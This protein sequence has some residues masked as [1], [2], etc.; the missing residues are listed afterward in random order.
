MVKLNCKDTR[1]VKALLRLSLIPGLLLMFMLPMTCPS[2]REVFAKGEN[3][4]D[5]GNVL[6]RN[7]RAVGAVEPDGR[8]TN[9]Y[10]K[11]IGSVDGSGKVFNV[12]EKEVGNISSS[13]EVFN[14]TGTLL[15]RVDA[16]GNIYRRSGN[17]VGSVVDIGGNIN[18]I[19]GAARL[20]LLK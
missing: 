14:Q 8:V 15:G 20:L 19:G 7:G 17:K 4:E 10:G 12:R 1:K 2:P 9:R 13:G 18:L 3:K 5:G 11:T 16:E 6:N